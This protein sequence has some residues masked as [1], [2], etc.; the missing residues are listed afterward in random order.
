MHVRLCALFVVCTLPAVATAGPIE[1]RLERTGFA[2]DPGLPM[3]D[4]A[5]RPTFEAG[6]FSVDPDTRRAAMSPA[7][8]NF[9]ADRL[10]IPMPE[11]LGPSGGGRWVN[12]GNFRIDYRLTDVA[13]GES[14]DLS[15]WGRAHGNAYW[16]TGGW[17]G[18]ATYWFGDRSERVSL[19]GSDYV[20]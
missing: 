12:I 2:I 16:G 20:I 14:R 5:L 18:G 9:A 6:T 10:P 7:L 13:S 17:A 4:A 8:V 3:L 11:D 19:G 1:F 15:M